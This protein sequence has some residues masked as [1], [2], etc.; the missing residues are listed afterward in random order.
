MA[1]E[2]EIIFS[3]SARIYA[4]LHPLLSSYCARKAAS[5]TLKMKHS[6]RPLNSSVNKV[7]IIAVKLHKL[8]GQF[9]VCRRE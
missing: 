3:L 2:M 6:V 4:L 8:T 7:K 1:D 9:Q 5:V